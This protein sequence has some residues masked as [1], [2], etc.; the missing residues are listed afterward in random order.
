MNQIKRQLILDVQKLDVNSKVEIFNYLVSLNVGFMEN[1]NGVFFSINDISDDLL[2]QL[3]EKLIILQQFQ[4]HNVKINEMLKDSN[5]HNHN[6]KYKSEFLR[7]LNEEK[8]STHHE[9]ESVKE[10][11]LSALDNNLID[12]ED[13]TTSSKT[14]DENSFFEKSKMSEYDS[15]IKDI[16]NRHNKMNKKHS[17]YVKYSV[18]KKKYNKQSISAEN[19]KKIENFYLNELEEE[20]YIF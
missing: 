2:F 7:S 3:R 20:S 9:T 14:N 4:K 13:P 1:T 11:T 18:A 6:H 15:V 10:N 16:E 19:N 17:I 5:N 8:I 12:E